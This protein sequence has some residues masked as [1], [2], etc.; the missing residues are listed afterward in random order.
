[1]A[2]KVALERHDGP[3]CLILTRQKV[4]VLDRSKFPPAENLAKGA[5]ILV[6]N[7]A[8]KP[9]L[10]L[11]SAGSEMQFTLAAAEQLKNETV[12]VRVVAMPSME[13]FEK[14]PQAYKDEVLPPAVRARGGRGRSPH[15][16]VQVCRPGRRSGGDGMLRGERA[17][18]GAV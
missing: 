12:K 7:A 5:Y 8:E 15:V 16:L 14:Q 9:D 11:I 3:T 6:G 2:W 1:V 18:Q 10:V 17:A 13:L 4:P